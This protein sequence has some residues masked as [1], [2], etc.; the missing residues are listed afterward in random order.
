MKKLE[1]V[2]VPS[3][4]GKITGVDA[5]LRYAISKTLPSWI[6]DP[7]LDYRPWK[8]SNRASFEQVKNLTLIFCGTALPEKLYQ[9]VV[10]LIDK[11]KKDNS[12]KMKY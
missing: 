8:K 12:Y 1:V 3:S 2:D 5:S 10:R 7:S 9:P 4:F 6:H 11:S